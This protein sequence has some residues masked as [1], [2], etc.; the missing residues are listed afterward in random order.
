MKHTKLNKTYKA[1]ITSSLSLEEK[2][3]FNLICTSGKLKSG[4]PEFRFTLEIGIY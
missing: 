3:S 1:L 2:E 4:L